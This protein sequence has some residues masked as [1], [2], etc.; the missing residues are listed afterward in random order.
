MDLQKLAY[1]EYISFKDRLASYSLWPPQLSQSD[2]SLAHAG[3]FYSNVS[4]RVTCFACG[5]MLWGWKADDDP[6]LQHYK[7]GR[8]CFYMKMV[9]GVRL[10]DNCS[11]PA[12]S[13]KPYEMWKCAALQ[14]PWTKKKTNDEP[15]E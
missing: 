15:G 7:H 6:W 10:E 1:P 8:N 13:T 12:M 5:V 3:L 11:T 14:G 4:D 9:G 2:Y